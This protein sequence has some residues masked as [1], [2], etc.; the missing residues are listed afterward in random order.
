MKLAQQMMGNQ[1]L[2]T[3]LNSPAAAGLHAR[4]AHQAITHL[5]FAYEQNE[6]LAQSLL[7]RR[8]GIWPWPILP[9]RR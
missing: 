9:I 8:V 4:L 1:N 5:R 6:G 3:E 7:R 2:Q